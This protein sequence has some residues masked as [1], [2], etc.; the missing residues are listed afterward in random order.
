MIDN[1]KVEVMDIETYKRLFLYCSYV[2]VTN[3]KFQFEISRKKN[4][5]NGLIKHLRDYKRDYQVTFNGNHFD[6]QVIQFI[7]ENYEEWDEL[8]SE[9]IVTLIYEFCQ[10]IIDNQKY[11]NIKLPYQEKYFDIPQIDLRLLNHYDNRARMV[12]LKFAYEFSLDGDIEELPIDFRQDYLTDDE[13]E[14]VISYCHVDVYATYQGYKI[15]RGNTEH[16]DYKGKD[17]IQLRLDLIK[18]YDLPGEAINWNDVKIGAELNKLNYLKMS[19]INHKELWKRIKEKKSKT[20]FK[21]RDCFPSYMKFET[22]EFQDFFERLG[23]TVVNL[24]AKQEFLFVHKGVK[25]LFAK[26]GGHSQDICR[27]ITPVEGCVIVDCDVGSM[28]PNIIRKRELYPAHLGTVWNEAYVS[29]IPKRL[30][31]KRLYKKTGEKKYDNF[32]ECF[33]LVMNGCFGRLIDRHDWQYDPFCGM[34][35]TIGGQV[36]IFMLME[37]F[38]Q[39]EGLQMLSMNTDGLTAMV[40]INKLQQYYN[41]CIAWEKQVGNDILG[42]LEYVEYEKLVQTSVNDYIAVKKADWKEVNGKFTA[43]P[44]DKSLEKRLK[45]KGSFLTSYELHKNKSNRIVPLALEKYF[46][47]GIPV[48]DTIRNHTNIYDFCIAKKASKDYCYRQVDRQTGN[49]VELNKLVRYYCAA[50]NEKIPIQ[51]EKEITNIIPGKLYKI[52]K[53]NSEARGPKVSN[54]EASSKLQVIFNKPF[55]VKNFKDYNID[56]GW[57]ISKAQDIICDIDPYY[58]SDRKLKASGALLLFN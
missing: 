13:I 56:L 49:V 53:E 21:F 46:T 31:A 55:S 17:K 42:Q 16:E 10:E 19:K 50:T 2:P 36:D 51:D 30:E 15:A 25:Y 58:K 54:C 34:N 1:L 44:I 7:L 26:G 24:N 39:I 48:E 57:Y 23:E 37:D 18:E 22:K 38:T 27:I 28:Y 9:E 40:P 52:K 41:V 47:Q 29:N 8:T 43:V 45:K 5:L 33:K 4:Q 14:A 32:Q 35:V 6:F 11:E 20:G 3:E 12:S